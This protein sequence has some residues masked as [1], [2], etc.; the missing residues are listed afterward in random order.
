MKDHTFH[1][2]THSLHTS[3]PLG[4]GERRG[5]FDPRGEEVDVDD[6]RPLGTLDVIAAKLPK[7]RR[8]ELHARR[9]AQRDRADRGCELRAQG[10][11][12]AYP[13]GQP[14]SAS[15]AIVAAMLPPTTAE[16]ARR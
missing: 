6:H 2:Q 16:F 1:T 15:D 4:P 3:E 11:T 13:L 5:Y 7:E 10:V 14:T 8:H 12:T 9:D